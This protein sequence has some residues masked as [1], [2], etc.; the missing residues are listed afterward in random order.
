MIC[1]PLPMSKPQQ[2]D[3]D[4]K[5][6]ILDKTRSLLIQE[7][8]ANLSMRKI[9]KE[10]GYSAT[11][12]YLH[13]KNKDALFHALID[14]GMNMLLDRQ[15]AISASFARVSDRLRALCHGYITFG[16]EAPEYYEIM[17][18]QHPKLSDRFPIESFRR[19]RKNLLLVRDTLDE[20]V[21]NGSFEVQDTNATTNVIWASLHG[22][23]SILLARR[24]DIH[25]DQRQFVNNVV[26]QVL[27]GVQGK[28]YAASVALPG[29]R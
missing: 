19:A 12:I 1:D 27:R 10:I 3:S 28:N 11:S 18:L 16:L 4:L 24:L 8:Y 17:F 2:S 21:R 6:L 14:E 29:S 15:E 13:F 5:R 25:A 7:G 23:V 9:A 20:G 22:A 26:D